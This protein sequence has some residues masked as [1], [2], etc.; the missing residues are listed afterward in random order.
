MEDGIGAGELMDN[1]EQ[2]LLGREELLVEPAKAQVWDTMVGEA[3]VVSMDRVMEV[4]ED[5]VEGGELDL[6]EEVLTDIKVAPNK[7]IFAYLSQAKNIS[8]NIHIF[9]YLFLYQFLF[10]A[11]PQCKLVIAMYRV[12]H[13]VR[14][15]SQV[16]QI[17]FGENLDPAR[18]YFVENSCHSGA[19]R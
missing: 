2:E 18:K 15:C 13:N 12:W 1:L 14:L 10:S 8:V 9:I 17:V 6:E 16:P 7:G 19:T 5:V 4:M 3:M 11:K